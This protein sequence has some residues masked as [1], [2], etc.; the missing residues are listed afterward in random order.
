MVTAHVSTQGD[1]GGGP[2]INAT[3]NPL[4]IK[5]KWYS[6]YD[7]KYPPPQNTQHIHTHSKKRTATTTTSYFSIKC[8]NYRQWPLQRCITTDYTLPAWRRRGSPYTRRTKKRWRCRR[9]WSPRRSR[10]PTPPS[11]PCAVWGGSETPHARRGK[12]V[13]SRGTV[14]TESAAQERHA[15][16]RRGRTGDWGHR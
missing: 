13:V 5:H 8:K 2:E 12:G 6:E 16:R 9:P 3:L 10:P 7:M 1:N 15:G 4:S 11:A 14:V